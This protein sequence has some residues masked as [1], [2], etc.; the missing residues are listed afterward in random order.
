MD[1]ADQPF[2][3]ALPQPG[4]R[5]FKN[6][7]KQGKFIELHDNSQWEIPPNYEIFTDYWTTETDVTVVPGGEK[8]YP[9]DLLNAATGDR[10]PARF[11]GFAHVMAAWKLIEN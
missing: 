4:V 1:M 6:R 11:R 3:K 10:V 2:E 7:L 8:N 9:Y 5:R